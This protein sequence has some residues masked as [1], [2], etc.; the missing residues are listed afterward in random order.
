MDKK[1]N[2]LWW[3]GNYGGKKQHYFPANY[4]QEIN[5][6]DGHS[7]DSGNDSLMLG[8]LQKGITNINSRYFI[9]HVCHYRRIS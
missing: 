1:G 6:S 3:T 7:D 2:E 9:S 8:S 5:T 4:V